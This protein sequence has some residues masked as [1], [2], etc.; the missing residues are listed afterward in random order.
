M[1]S[2]FQRFKIS[3]RAACQC[4]PEY[5]LVAIFRQNLLDHPLKNPAIRAGKCVKHLDGYFFIFTH[6]FICLPFYLKRSRSKNK[7]NQILVSGLP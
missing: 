6:V 1:Y 4:F 2:Q 7:K 3:C 5:E